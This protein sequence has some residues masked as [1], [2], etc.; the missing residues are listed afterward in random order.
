[1]NLHDDI[2]EEIHSNLKLDD[3]QFFTKQLVEDE[4]YTVAE[5]VAISLERKT[6]YITYH[7]GGECRVFNTL[8]EAI[9]DAKIAN[10]RITKILTFEESIIY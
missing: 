8:S 10:L 2:K 5:A 6:N 9:E 7:F 1:M 4:N 3:I